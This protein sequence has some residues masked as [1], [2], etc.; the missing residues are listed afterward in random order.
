M[1]LNKTHQE[2]PASRK[3]LSILS[4]SLIGTLCLLAGLGIGL[5]IFNSQ[6][7]KIAHLD[8]SQVFSEFSLTKELQSKLSN[9]EQARTTI[10]ENMELRLADLNARRNR[11][12]TDSIQALQIELNTKQQQFAEDHNRQTQQYNEQIWTQLNQYIQDYCE[13]EGYSY[14]L[15]ANGSGNLMGADANRDVTE[16]L[17]QFVNQ[18][19]SG[20]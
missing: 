7:P 12:N 5:S 3:G 9:T 19:Y 18:Q 20:S 13:V 16:S 10:L 11:T 1:H 17:I 14:I 6:S 4:V 15:G 8:P 2:V